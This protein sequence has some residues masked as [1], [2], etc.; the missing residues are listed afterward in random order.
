M[1]GLIFCMVISLN[2][3]GGQSSSC[4]NYHE[5]CPQWCVGNNESC[6]ITETETYFNKVCY[7]MDSSC[8][9]AASEDTG[10]L[11]SN[12]RVVGGKNL[13]IKYC[14]KPQP[15]PD[16][17]ET[18]SIGTIISITLNVLFAVIIATAIIIMLIK[19]FRRAGNYGRMDSGIYNDT[20][21]DIARG[22]DD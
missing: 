20:I 22:E 16:N 11:L 15:T 6:S 14:V 19:R 18:M 12:G 2:F 7:K 9:G 17:H 8:D 13:W 4:P 1:S 10:C 21:E 3:I 5:D